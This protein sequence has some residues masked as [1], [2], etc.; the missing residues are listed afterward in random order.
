MFFIAV[1]SLKIERIGVRFEDK[2]KDRASIWSISKTTRFFFRTASLITDSI[3]LGRF[4]CLLKLSVSQNSIWSDLV[5]APNSQIFFQVCKA[6]RALQ[7]TY[8][9]QLF[10][11]ARQLDS[12]LF[13]PHLEQSS[14][15]SN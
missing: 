1:I 2:D 13:H 7:P 10:H 12:D 14:L 6:H 11:K 5:Q 9:P 4:I 8:Q 3:G 15:K